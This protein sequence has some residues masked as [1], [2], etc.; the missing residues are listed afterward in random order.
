MKRRDFL[1]TSGLASG[2]LLVPAFLSPWQAMGQAPNSQ[3]R[4][5]VVVQLDGGNDGLNT[6]VPFEHDAYHRKRPGLGISKR[7]VLPLTDTLGLNPGMQAFKE[8][9]E[10]GYISI[11][12]GVGYPNPDRSHFRS[13]DIWHS[14][15]GAHQYWHS[16]WLGRY[17]DAYCT[18]SYQGIEVSRTLS[19]ALK[20]Q[21]RKGLAM[22][23]AQQLHNTLREP[24]FKD[25]TPGQA[26]LAQEAPVSYLY[27]TLAETQSSADYIFEKL[28]PKAKGNT[29][30]GYPDH[31]LGKQLANVAQLIAAGLPT[32]VFYVS[33][34][35]FDTHVA[36]AGKHARLLGQYAGALKAFAHD[37]KQ[38]GQ[39]QNTL[40][41]TFSEFGRRVAQNASGGTDH[42]TANNVFLAGGQLARPGIYN[43][44]PSLTALDTNGDL[45]Y[46]L[47]FRHI[48]AS[49]LQEWLQADATQLMQGP[50]KL[51]G[52][53]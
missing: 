2:A 14:G 50:F 23:N 41:L 45:Q 32:Q 35:G 22:A 16:G 25:L 3:N 27:K 1:K 6:V 51:L 13:M 9:Y 17:L 18:E 36:Q 40:V 44:M 39:W 26:T 34:S 42:G 52:L 20:G 49:I 5:L 24:F 48:Y 38:M 53:V 47:D 29:R 15:S 8:L 46:S 12:N 37:L 30:R 33:L 28:R 43:A 10:Q 31:K 4:R 11:F 21:Q 19:L 7:K